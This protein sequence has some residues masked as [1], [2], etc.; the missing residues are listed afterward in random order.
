MARNPVTGIDRDAID[1]VRTDQHEE[2]VRPPSSDDEVAAYRAAYEASF[3]HRLTPVQVRLLRSVCEADRLQGLSVGDGGGWS[4]GTVNRLRVLGLIVVQQP[5]PRWRET[6]Y[7]HGG[8]EYVGKALD[9]GD[10]KALITDSGRRE[11]A[12][13]A[14]AASSF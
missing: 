14:G 4:A 6:R 1:A 12:V 7:R 2:S 13:R 11:A 8:R 9:Y 3:P 10:L 5:S